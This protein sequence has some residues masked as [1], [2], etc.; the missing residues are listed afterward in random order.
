MQ[1]HDRPAEQTGMH[2]AAPRLDLAGA[3]PP[4]PTAVRS[5]RHPAMSGARMAALQ[6]SAGNRA[7]GHLVGTHAPSPPAVVELSRPVRGAVAPAVVQRKPGG[8]ADQTANIAKLTELRANSDA[9]FTLATDYSADTLAV[10]DAVHDKLSILSGIY[11]QAYETFRGVLNTAQQDA[12]NQQMW[13]DIIVGVICGAAA[14][15]LAAWV[16]PSTAAGW[17]ALTAAEVGT[18]TA[19][20]FGQAVLGAAAA[21]ALS[22]VT[23]VEGKAISSDGLD[24]AF[25]ELAMWKKVAEIYRSGLEVTPLVKA[26]HTLSGNLADRIADLRVYAAGGKSDL[27]DAKIA[28]AV[29]T[30]TQQDAAQATA[31]DELSQRLIAL[32][33]VK[34]AGKNIPT[35]KPVPAMEREIWRM[36]MS[37]L[38]TNSNI[39]DINAIEDHIGPKGL[40]IIDFGLVTTRADQNEAIESA[41]NTAAHM[42]AEATTSLVPTNPA[43]RLKILTR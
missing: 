11:S 10:G 4:M 3:A 29:A 2:A 38:P 16:L 23:N 35:D 22:S 13:T 34:L 42:K 43:E 37:T 41:R 40:K 21:T 39:L 18:A 8:R 5:P 30:L 1:S 28:A 19:S 32:Q 36:W 17:F 25:M 26:S 20:G 31:R 14:S 7:V 12:Q 33:D 6:R 9:R 15:L 24:P 27:T